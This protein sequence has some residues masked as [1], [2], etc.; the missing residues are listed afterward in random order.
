MHGSE[1]AKEKEQYLKLHRASE[2]EKR[3]W[4]VRESAL[5]MKMENM[6]LENTALRQENRALRQ[7][8]GDLRA[9]ISALRDKVK[10]LEEDNAKLLALLSNQ[11]QRVDHLE[12]VLKEISSEDQKRQCCM[13]ILKY[14]RTVEENV[15]RF[16]WPGVQS[17]SCL[18]SLSS[19]IEFLAWVRDLPKPLA[20]SKAPFRRDD[21]WEEFVGLSE[22]VRH[23]VISRFDSL[24]GHQKFKHLHRAIAEVT[25]ELQGNVGFPLLAA[26][27]QE[28]ESYVERHGFEFIQKYFSKLEK[29]VHLIREF[30]EKQTLNT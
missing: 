28:V 25:D 21:A 18:E 29:P 23:G 15:I 1:L 7:E 24:L 17:H 9:E 12:S 14:A 4:E 13:L 22:E 6:G 8:V 26:P 5:I 11:E 2:E 30:H 3:E 10:V 16:L 20:D 19:C 27:S